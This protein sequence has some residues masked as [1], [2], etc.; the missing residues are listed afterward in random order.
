M[1]GMASWSPKTRPNSQWIDNCLME[2]GPLVVELTFV[3]MSPK[4]G[5]LPWGQTFNPSSAR[6]KADIFKINGDDDFMS[7]WVGRLLPNRRRDRQLNLSVKLQ[8]TK[9]FT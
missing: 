6:K 9:E 3:T 2:I 5:R 4:V 7:S 8:F 1:S